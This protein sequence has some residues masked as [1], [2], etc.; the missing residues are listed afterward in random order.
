MLKLLNIPSAT[1]DVEQ[2]D[3]SYMFGEIAKWSNTLKNSEA[4]S[5]KVTQTTTIRPYNF[6]SRCLLK[7]IKNMLIYYVSI[8]LIDQNWKQSKPPSASEQISKLWYIPH[9]GMLYSKGKILIS[10]TCK[11]MDN[12]VREIKHNVLHVI[13]HHLCEFLKKLRVIWKGQVVS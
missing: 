6:T 5:Y 11:N 13:W 7:K 1:E 9:C 2:A 12:S 3:L 10:N 4:V 8:I